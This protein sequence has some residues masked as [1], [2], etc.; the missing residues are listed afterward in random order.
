[1]LKNYNYL[2]NIK[3]KKTNHRFSLK[4]TILHHKLELCNKIK[5]Q[6]DQNL[7]QYLKIKQERKYKIEYM[8]L[9]SLALAHI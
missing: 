9:M 1:M 6:K 4:I 2:K 5:N 3:I 7:Q 8:H